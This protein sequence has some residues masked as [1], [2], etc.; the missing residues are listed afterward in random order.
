MII[1][2]KFNC[3]NIIELTNKC[4]NKLIE[5]KFIEPKLKKKDINEFFKNLI[6]EIDEEFI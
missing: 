6:E 2:K 1:E 3:K 5:M 4:Y